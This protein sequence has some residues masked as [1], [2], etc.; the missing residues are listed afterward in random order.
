ME[1]MRSPRA[2]ALTFPASARN[3]PRSWLR[4]SHGISSLRAGEFYPT[5]SKLQP[6]SAE[7]CIPDDLAQKA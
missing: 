3:H 5:H 4:I 2:L 1:T 6:D 7:T